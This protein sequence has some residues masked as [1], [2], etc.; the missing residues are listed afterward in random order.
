M[1]AFVI[2]MLI[3]PSSA[4]AFI[5]IKSVPCKKTPVCQKIR[6]DYDK[7]APDYSKSATAADV[8]KY[9]FIKKK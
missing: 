2:F 5:K 8:R 3:L 7:A 4:T 9:C 6:S 1:K